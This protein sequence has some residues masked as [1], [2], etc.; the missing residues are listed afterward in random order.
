MY[1]KDGDS[2]VIEL[3]NIKTN[4]TIDESTYSLN[5]K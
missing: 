1:E 4:Q 5:R 2:S 3:T